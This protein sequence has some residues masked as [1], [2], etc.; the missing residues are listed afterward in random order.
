MRR[1]F[2][3]A[4]CLLFAVSVVL[5][6]GGAGKYR[7]LLVLCCIATQLL[8][9]YL[10]WYHLAYIPRWREASRGAGLNL[11]VLVPVNPFL[12]RAVL[13]SSGARLCPGRIRRAFELHIDAPRKYGL[14]EFA[15]LLASDLY[16]VAEG[17]EPGTLVLWE[18][19]APVPAAFRRYV[20][21]KQAA[22]EAVWER[23]GWGLVHRYAARSVRHGALVW[24]GTGVDISLKGAGS[25]YDGSR[26]LSY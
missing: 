25:F 17:L 23:G 10:F 11:L 24:L 21:W 13:L 9:A 5:F 12:A 7:P 3:S 2:L 26:G 8:T 22:G 6:I 14:A 18:T 15:R 16:C 1:F 20:R 4:F 19:A